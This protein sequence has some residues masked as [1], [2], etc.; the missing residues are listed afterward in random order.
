MGVVATVLTV[1]RPMG[2]VVEWF[3]GT[4]I[5][6]VGKRNRIANYRNGAP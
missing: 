2:V 5:F 4:L 1:L 3:A 6:F